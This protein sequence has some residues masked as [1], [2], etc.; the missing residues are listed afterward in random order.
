MKQLQKEFNFS[1]LLITHNMGVANEM[2]NKI[3]IMYAGKIM[4]YGDKMTIFTKPAHP[5][6]FGLIRSIPPLYEDINELY[7]IQGNPVDLSNP[8]KGCR[9]HPRCSYATEICRE[10]TPPLIK[11]K[12]GSLVACFY[13]IE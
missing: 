1:C 4:E 8:P 11:S 10:K 13:P 9:F 12:S 7:I 3:A 2:C 5:Y 6:T